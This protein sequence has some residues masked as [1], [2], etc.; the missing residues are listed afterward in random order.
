MSPTFTATVFTVPSRG[1]RSAFSIFMASIT[2]TS[3]PF[4]TAWPG[5]AFTAMTLPGIVRLKPGLRRRAAPARAPSVCSSI[6]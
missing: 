2:T 1:A 5:T 3:S 6:R 4:F